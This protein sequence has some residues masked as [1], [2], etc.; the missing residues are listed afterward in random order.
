MRFLNDQWILFLWPILALFS[1]S[2]S[3]QWMKESERKLIS[4]LPTLHSHGT[5]FLREFG[6]G[7]IAFF[8]VS[9]WEQPDSSCSKDETE[10]MKFKPI[11]L[12]SFYP[13]P[14]DISSHF[15]KTMGITFPEVQFES[16]PFVIQPVTGIDLGSAQ[17]LPSG[18]GK[19]FGELC[20]SALRRGRHRGWFRLI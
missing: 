15:G 12:C 2:V 8:P 19:A 1:Q 11:P 20:T 14:R 17:R 13:Q 7:A 6:W 3:D 18:Q 9:V 10:H 5:Y 16:G 4:M